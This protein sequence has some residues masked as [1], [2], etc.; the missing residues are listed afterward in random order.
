MF[1][2]VMRGNNYKSTAITEKQADVKQKLNINL[3][4]NTLVHCARESVLH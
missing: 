2:M 4:T 1:R 3:Y